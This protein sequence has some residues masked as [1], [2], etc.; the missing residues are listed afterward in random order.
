M[1]GVGFMIWGFDFDA[2]DE[3]AMYDEFFRLWVL[4]GIFLMASGVLR[5]TLDPFGSL[6]VK[7]PPP[8]GVY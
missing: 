3:H 7:T 4:E 6:L 1:N 8:G 5:S 2:F